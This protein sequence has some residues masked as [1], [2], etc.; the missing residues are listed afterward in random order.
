MNLRVL[1]VYKSLQEF[2]KR[3]YSLQMKTEWF[4]NYISISHKLEFVSMYTYLCILVGMCI[5][6]AKKSRKEYFNVATSW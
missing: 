6:F 5:F 2:C 3:I 1:D 4:G